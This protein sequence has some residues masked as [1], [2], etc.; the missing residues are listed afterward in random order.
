MKKI[1][2]ICLIL[3]AVF[4]LAGCEDYLDVNTN[5]NG[6]DALLAWTVST[7]SSIVP[8]C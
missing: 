1:R 2:N 8:S 3:A 5:P 6:P 4:T 7:P